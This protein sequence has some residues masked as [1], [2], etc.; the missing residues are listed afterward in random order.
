MMSLPAPLSRTTFCLLPLS[1]ARRKVCRPVPDVAN[2][3]RRKLR[4]DPVLLECNRIETVA[5]GCLIAKARCCRHRHADSARAP[6]RPTAGHGLANFAEYLRQR[7]VLLLGDPGLPYGPANAP[8]CDGH[9]DNSRQRRSGILG[10]E[11]RWV[12]AQNAPGRCWSLQA[13]SLSPFP[14]FP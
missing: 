2:I 6:L 9:R 11:A 4:P 1:C 7:R 5:A 13:R 14:A 3:A 10:G 12:R 8:R